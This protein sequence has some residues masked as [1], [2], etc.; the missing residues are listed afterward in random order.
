M[1]TALVEIALE[2]ALADFE[3]SKETSALS[4]KMLERIKPKEA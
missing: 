3:T 2:L 4:V 1:V